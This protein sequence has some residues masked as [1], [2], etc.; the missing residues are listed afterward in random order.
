M[1]IEYANNFGLA[2]L[3]QLRGRIGR[4]NLE[5][6]CVL[7]YHNELSQEGKDRLLVMKNSNDGF[8][9]S[10]QDL[11]MRGSGEIFGTKQT[12]LPSWK[13]FNPYLDLELISDV[14]ENCKSLMTSYHKNKEKIN[15][16]TSSF[17]DKGK[18]DNYFTG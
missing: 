10:E 5:S 17:F 8:Y 15:F 18:I 14:R 4:N 3:H 6:N 13:F 1:I 12:G 2:Q 9:I 7:L 16:L 11:K